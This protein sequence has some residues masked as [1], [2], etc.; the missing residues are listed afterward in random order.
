M[1]FRTLDQGHVHLN[2]WDIDELRRRVRGDL[3]E[4]DDAS[5][6]DARGIFNGMID[7]RPTLIVRCTGVADV[8]AAADFARSN[9][10]LTSVRGGGHGIAG[11]AVCDGGLM[12]SLERMNSVHVD[13]SRRIGWVSGGAKLGDVDHETAARPGVPRGRRVH[14]RRCRV[15]NGRRLW[16]ATRE[17]GDVD[18]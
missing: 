9:R 11:T 12:I 2:T 8:I 10:L 16:M 1:Q 3:I 14:D 15:D 17:I 13:P 6:D 5:Y 7:R 18:R 4:P